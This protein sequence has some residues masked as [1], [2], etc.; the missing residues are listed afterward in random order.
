MIYIVRHG[1]TDRNVEGVFRGRAFD[2]ELNSIGVQ[3][4]KDIG[5]QLK[6]IKF[7]ICYCSPM[8]RTR[9]TFEQIS[10]CP[11]VLDERILPIQYD[12][13]LIGK[14]IKAT[15]KG[16]IDYYVRTHLKLSDDSESILEFE[17]RV[18][19]FF[20]E[21]CEK[22]ENQNVLVVT[23]SSTCKPI[24]G[25]FLG[26]PADNSYSSFHTKNGEIIKGIKKK[27]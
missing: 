1:E 23:H 16:P 11:L 12:S 13:S 9:Q 18:F 14:S 20:D 24:K 7:D 2:D 19:G 4:A 21:I 15:A 27:I 26:I 10:K 25:Y 6:D 8:K 5:E 22:H 17:A 3:Q